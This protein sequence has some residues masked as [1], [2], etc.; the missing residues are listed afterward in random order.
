[1]WDS[2]QPRITLEEIENVSYLL[3]YAHG[4]VLSPVSRPAPLYVS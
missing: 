3:C 4:I 1:V 2:A